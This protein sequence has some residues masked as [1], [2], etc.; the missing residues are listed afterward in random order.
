[1][2]IPNLLVT[3]FIFINLLAMPA[4]GQPDIKHAIVYSVD[5]ENSILRVYVGRAGPLAR[6]GHNHVVHTRDISGQIELAEN[7]MNS[8]ASFSVPVGSFIVDDQSERD[9][10]GDGFDSQPDESAIEG[11]RDNM[12]SDEVLNAAEYNEISIAAS[13]VGVDDTEWLL[14]VDIA[15]QGSTFSQQLTAQVDI[16]EAQVDVSATFTLDHEDLGLSPFSALAGSLR[17]A[18]S[19]DFELQIHATAQ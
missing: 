18:E 8:S 9:R 2:R 3:G 7:L 16:S 12:L 15:F 11:T 17:V 1:M 14:A 13:P 10:A 5:S 19:I 4:F 6:L